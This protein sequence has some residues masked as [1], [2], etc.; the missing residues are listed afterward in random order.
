MKISIITPSYNQGEFIE[1]T[2]LSVLNQNYSNYEHIIVDAGSTDKTLEI[3]NK[4]PHL[5]WISEPDEGQSDALNKG[6]KM[7]TGDVIGWLNSDEIY[8]PGVFIFVNKVFT[9]GSFD[10]FY[11]D[12]ISNKRNIRRLC[13][14]I[15]P[16]K[17]MILF[18]Q[19]INTLTLFFSRRVIDDGNF[20]EMKYSATMDKEFLIRIERLGYNFKYFPKTMGEFHWHD[21]NKSTVIRKIQTKES[22]DIVKKYFF[23]DNNILHRILFWPTKFCYDWVF[24]FSKQYHRIFTR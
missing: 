10:A 16:I 1:K 14:G 12:Y 21:N 7:A 5:K 18:R 24:Y 13:V 22:I 19:Y 3:L 23:K 9:K 11:G 17:N 8:Y 6:L 20:I 15:P 2:I 4:Y